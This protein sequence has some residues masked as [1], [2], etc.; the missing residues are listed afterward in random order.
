MKGIGYHHA[1]L[2]SHDRHITEELFTQGDLLVLGKILL[3]SISSAKM[4]TFTTAKFAM[5]TDSNPVCLRTTK[6]A[7]QFS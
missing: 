3:F 6:A 1:G 2:D 7:T 5:I 4:Q